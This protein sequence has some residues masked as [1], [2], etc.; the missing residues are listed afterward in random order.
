MMKNSPLNAAFGLESPLEELK[1]RRI[2]QQR[3]RLNGIVEVL[4]DEPWKYG[5]F[6]AMRFF[7][8][9]SP[10]MP[11]LGEAPSPR[12]EPVKLAQYISLAFAPSSVAKV[13]TS[14]SGKPRIEQYV[15]GLLGVNGPMPIHLTE[16]TRDRI[17]H[18]RDLTLSR[19]LDLFNNRLTLLFYRSWAQAQP[20]ISLDRPDDSRFSK[21]LGTLFGAA[22]ES[23]RNKDALPD[24]AKYFFA[25]HLS[26]PTKNAEGLSNWIRD[27]FRIEAQVKV[28]QAHWMKLP[29]TLMSR[30]GRND[31]SAL[32]RGAVLGSS[33]WD[34]QHRFRIRL[35]PL[36]WAQFR[37]FL[38]S[39]RGM[40]RLTA[41]VRNY[42]GLELK[43]DVQI[44]L[45]HKE[46]P[47]LVLDQKTRDQQIGR[48]G[49][50]SW[51]GVYRKAQDDEQLI[52]QL[53]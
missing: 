24:Y 46:V 33:V 38:P 26:N 36:N 49:R 50:S 8:A 47:S 18:H 23:S 2:Q 5:L 32:G 13:S 35:G 22:G 48:L 16:Y 27:Y 41:M 25:G 14:A 53:V 39:E 37:G 7:E 28:Y 21:Y 42:A 43:W 31:T 15:Y 30:L 6:Q 51:L 52:V 44:C 11:R 4:H 34:V 45:S 1:N 20:A 17:L 29:K 40:A 3:S 12:G 19:F 9:L 10:D